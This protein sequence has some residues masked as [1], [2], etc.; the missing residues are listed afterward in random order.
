MFS[1]H[2]SIVSFMCCVSACVYAVPAMARVDVFRFVLFFTLTFTLSLFFTLSFFH[3]LFFTLLFFTLAYACTY[4]LVFSF[5]S[6]VVPGDVFCL[7]VFSSPFFQIRMSACTCVRV[8]VL[9]FFSLSI[10]L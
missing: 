3:S 5:E 10:H 2:H 9:L 7:A 6:V 1:L 4:A 8:T